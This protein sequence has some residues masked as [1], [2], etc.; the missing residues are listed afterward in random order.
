MFQT[1]VFYSDSFA[2]NSLIHNYCPKRRMFS[3]RPFPDVSIVFKQGKGK[4]FYYSFF[5]V[6]MQ[7]LLVCQTVR[8]CQTVELV[9][10]K[11]SKTQMKKQKYITKYMVWRQSLTC[12]SSTPCSC[13]GTCV[14]GRIISYVM[15]ICKGN[16]S[17]NEPC[18]LKHALAT[19]LNCHGLSTL[20]I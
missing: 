4:D 20:W 11:S 15:C 5:S 8:H 1:L 2:Q 16:L 3:S 17:L 14:C 13:R 10:V 12:K 18:G 7:E 9:M 6:Q 19:S